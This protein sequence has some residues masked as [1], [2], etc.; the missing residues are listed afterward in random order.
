MLAFRFNDRFVELLE[1]GEPS[2]RRRP[3]VTLAERVLN[4]FMGGGRRGQC[5]KQQDHCRSVS[6]TDTGFDF[7]QRKLGGGGGQ[8]APESQL[9]TM[10]LVLLI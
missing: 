8:V 7:F 1:S 6:F 4:H 5:Y 2:S 9:W 10:V 3:P